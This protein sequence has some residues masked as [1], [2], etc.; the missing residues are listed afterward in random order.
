ME[1]DDYAQVHGQVWWTL[2]PEE[3][4]TLLQAAVESAV[5]GGFAEIEAPCPTAKGNDRWWRVRISTVESGKYGHMVVASSRDVTQDR[6][7]RRDSELRRTQAAVLTRTAR[8]VTEDL[9]RHLQ[10]EYAA[11]ADSERPWDKGL[12]DRVGRANSVFALLGR[13]L[14]DADRESVHPHARERLVAELRRLADAYE[15]ELGS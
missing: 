1:L 6:L 8:V 14:A 15:E 5:R 9:H 3:S 2:W 13:A 10:K 7:H 12:I 4:R 11:A